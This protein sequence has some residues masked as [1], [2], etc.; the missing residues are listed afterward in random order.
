MEHIDI[1]VVVVG[2]RVVA[3]DNEKLMRILI[4]QGLYKFFFFFSVF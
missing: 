2:G 4:I 3:Y 1:V